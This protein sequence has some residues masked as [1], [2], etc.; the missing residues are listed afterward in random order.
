MYTPRDHG[1]A[2]RPR[3]R[4]DGSPPPRPRR[5]RAGEI[6]APVGRRRNLEVVELGHEALDPRRVGL[7]VNPIDGGGA[8]ALEQLRD[9]LVGEDHQ[10]LDQPVRLG[11][12]DGAGLDRVAV[13]A[14]AELRLEGLDLETRRAAALSEPRGGSAGYRERL[15]NWLGGLSPAGEHLVEAVVVETS[16]G[17]D[18]A[19]VEARGDRGAAGAKQ[20][21]GRHRQ[22]LDIGRESAG[23]LA[24]GPGQHRLDASWHVGAVSAPARLEV[25]RGAG[26]HVGGDI[27]DVDPDPGPVSL[28]PGRDRVVEV[29]GGGRVDREGRHVDEIAARGELRSASSPARSAATC[30]EGRSRDGR[31]RRAAAPRPPRAR[32]ADPAAVPCRAGGN[33]GPGAGASRRRSSAGQHSQRAFQGLV[34]RRAGQIPGRRRPGG[35]RD[36]R[37]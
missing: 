11:L 29:A 20:N 21:L 16:V 36:R 12:G 17:A 18:P 19:A 26:R 24:Q 13:G 10:P 15:G 7:G 23:V 22:S 4:R 8:L 34:A 9:L 32:S 31:A 28:A 33:R 1:R 5:P 3:E 25:Q 27:G 30:S 2:A 14:E 37:G 6:A 35:F